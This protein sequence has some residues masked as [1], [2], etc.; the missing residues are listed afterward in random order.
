MELFY[1]T[2]D[3]GLAVMLAT[4]GVPFMAGEDGKPFPF[5]NVY[6]AA[7]LKR[8]GYPAGTPLETAARDAWKSGKRG[9]IVYNF[10]RND[11][12]GRLLEV[13]HAHG[14]TMTAADAARCGDSALTVGATPEVI[15]VICAQ[16]AKNRKM[17]TESWRVV[18]PCIEACDSRT[19]QREGATVIVGEHR[20][21]S[22]NASPELRAKV[23]I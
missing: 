7:I 1:Q 2:Q 6:T 12:C 21:V 17:L 4:A 5:F 18:S 19:E 14:K 9:R 11:L 13:W 3:T 20:L 22:L 23:G 16:F 15:A 8:Y 10:V